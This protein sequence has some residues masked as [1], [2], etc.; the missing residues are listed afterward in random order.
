MQPYVAIIKAT[1]ANYTSLVAAI[2]RLGITS[3]LTN[4]SAIIK[5][6]KWVILPGVGSADYAM[7]ELAKK[8]LINVI[9]TLKQPVLGICL[10]MQLLCSDSEEGDVNCLNIIPLKVQRL[11]T[12][13]VLPHM[14]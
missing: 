7:N 11:K 13:Q 6:A 12:K 8:Q 10:G 14:G 9:K 4:N 1:G 3:R 5:K 2:K